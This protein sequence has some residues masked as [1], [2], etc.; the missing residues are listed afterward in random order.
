MSKTEHPEIKSQQDILQQQHF[1]EREMLLGFSR[2]QYHELTRL[3]GE[4]RE[5]NGSMCKGISDQIIDILERAVT[6]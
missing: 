6:I 1:A 2:E 5:Y 3:M 4:Y